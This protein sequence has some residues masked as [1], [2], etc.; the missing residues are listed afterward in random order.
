[1]VAEKCVSSLF[2]LFF[3]TGMKALTTQ[4]LYIFCPC[5]NKELASY[6]FIK[7]KCLFAKLPKPNPCLLLG[8]SV[9]SPLCNWNIPI[10]SFGLH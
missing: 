9:F 6:F 1:M 2:E 8:F 7:E 5:S 3:V 10:W 4:N